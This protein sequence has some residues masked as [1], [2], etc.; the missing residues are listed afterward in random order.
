MESSPVISVIIPAYNEAD[1]IV[2]TVQAALSL[3]QVSEVIVVSDGSQDNTAEAASLGG[4]SRVIE[5]PANQGKGAALNAGLK[6]ASAPIILMLD[7]DLGESA[8]RAAPLIEPVAAGRCDMTVA[9]FPELT[10]PRKGGGMGIALRLARIGIRRLV[11]A[12]LIAPLSGQRTLRREIVES[13]G[14]FGSGFGVET[15]LSGW[16]AAGGWKVEEIPLEMTHRRTGKNAAGFVHR[17]KQ[18]AHILQALLWLAVHR[19]EAEKHR[20]TR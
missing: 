12:D 5:L 6:A 14:G 15:R 3:P 18:L 8:A 7:G 1:R 13:M 2:A 10:R 9:I 11:G 17:G 16:A 4:A 20:S 19:T